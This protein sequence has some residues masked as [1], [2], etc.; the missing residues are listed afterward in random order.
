[1]EQAEQELLVLA[2]VAATACLIL[3]LLLVV[4][5]Q[6]LGIALLELQAVQ[7]VAVQVEQLLKL[8]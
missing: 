1:L 4:E 6:D 8:T 2:Q 7:V 3:L 5:Q